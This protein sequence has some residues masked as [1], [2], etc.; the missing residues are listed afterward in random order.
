MVKKAKKKQ[1]AGK[2][3][4]AN[5]AARRASA[6]LKAVIEDLVIGNRI[7]YAQDIVD[8][9]G[10]VSARHPHHPDRFLMSRARAPGLV[11][12]AD[13]ME[14]GP[15]GELIRPDERP[16]Y[17]E[18]FIHSEVYKARTD[19]HGVVHS[20]SPTV[21]PFSVTQVPLQPIRASFFYPEVPVF[22][23]RD[24]AG[25]T[26]L[27]I[28]NSSLGKA[29]AE[30][31]GQNSVA[32]MRGH[33]DVVVGPSVRIAVY[34]AIYTEANAKLLLQAKMLGGPIT[35]LAPEEAALMA[36]EQV[37]VRPGHGFERTWEM[38]KQEALARTG[39]LR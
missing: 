37:R 9:Y 18:R 29:L 20:H 22:D 33:G 10:H 1:P 13:I 39:K 23:T 2:S 26:N 36:K 16:I 6:E 14:F 30:K 15:D 3:A 12:A 38:W 21:V 32:L 11:T 8:G 35:Y 19:V 24:V 31:L 7:L 25:F 4:K 17:S 34:R 5:A 27:L 28:S